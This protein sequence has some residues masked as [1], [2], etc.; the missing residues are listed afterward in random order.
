MLENFAI[1]WKPLELTV[2]LSENRVRHLTK[3]QG[4]VKLT[5]G[6]QQERNNIC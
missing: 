2:L 6:N 3:A 5:E 4:S 1:C